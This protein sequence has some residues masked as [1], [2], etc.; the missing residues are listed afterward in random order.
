M[1]L[2]TVSPASEVI[3]YQVLAASSQLLAILAQ[4]A[5][6]VLWGTSSMQTI[7]TNALSMAVSAALMLLSINASSAKA[8]CIWILLLVCARAVFLLVRLVKL[9]PSA[10]PVWMDTTRRRWIIWPLESAWPVTVTAKPALTLPPIASPAPL[11][12]I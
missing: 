7:A 12:P 3:R 9:L 11:G 2:S 8:A 4:A 1:P 5:P 6:F 10:R